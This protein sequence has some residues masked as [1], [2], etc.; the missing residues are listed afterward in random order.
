MNKLLE[1]AS[2]W[3]AANNPTEEKMQLAE[4][5]L[6]VCNSCEHNKLS[7]IFKYPQCAKC[8]CPLSKKVFSP[9]PG[10]EACPLKKW[11]K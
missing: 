1:I 7:E 3:I 6:Q 8:G 4:S 10:K 2:A 11:E 5:R 9:L